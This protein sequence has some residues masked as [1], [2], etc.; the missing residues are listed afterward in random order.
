MAPVKKEEGRRKTEHC[1]RSE[2]K[3]EEGRAAGARGRSEGVAEL[4]EIE[5]TDEAE[6]GRGRRGRG[7]RPER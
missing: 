7:R 4:A 6:V 1:R 2:D 5:I 3:E